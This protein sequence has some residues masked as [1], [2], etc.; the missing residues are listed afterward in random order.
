V[1]RDGEFVVKW[2]LESEKP[3]KGQAS[4]RVIRLIEKLRSEGEL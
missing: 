2:D 1:Y 4:T 3:M